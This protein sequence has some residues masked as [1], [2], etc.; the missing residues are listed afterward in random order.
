MKIFLNENGNYGG[1]YRI[2]NLENG[3]IYIGSTYRFKHRAKDHLND[4]VANRH[5]NKFLQNDFNKCGTDN[6]LFEVLE[7][8]DGDKKERSKIE[9]IHIDKHFDNQKNCY[10]FRKDASD[11]RQGNKAIQEINRDTDRRCKTPAQETLIK[12]GDAIRKAKSTPEQKEKAAANARNGLWKEHSANVTLIHKETKEEVLITTS[13]RQFAIDKG[14]SY[15]SLH[16]V[17]RGKIKSSGGWHLKT[18]DNVGLTYIDRKGEKRKP[19]SKEHKDKIALKAS[20]KYKHLK[21]VD[22]SG[23]VQQVPLNIKNFCRINQISYTTF[24][25]LLNNKVKS[26]NGWILVN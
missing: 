21:I 23:N 7:V 24:T 10:N 1:I 17:I 11:S 6:F 2:V 15:K 13:L 14:L 20:A 26:C 5:S 9:Q 8:V 4:L 16:Q 22:T 19:L 12:R 3:R 25:K 18:E